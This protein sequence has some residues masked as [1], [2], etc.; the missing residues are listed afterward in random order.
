MPPDAWPNWV[1][2]N[3]DQSR[4]ATRV[5]PAQTRVAAMLLLTLRGT[6]TVYYGDEIGMTDVPIPPHLVQDPAE[7]NQPGIGVGRDPERTPML[8]DASPNGGFTTGTPWLPTGSTEMN[9]AAQA[10]QPDS[11]L[12]LYRQLIALRRNNPA[13]VVGAV[14]K[15]TARGSLLS[16]TRS[17]AGQR[18]QVLLNMGHAPCA[19]PVPEGVGCCSPPGRWRWSRRGHAVPGGG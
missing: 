8:W 2:G 6:P 19:V 10:G 15:V 13:L 7:K 3:H 16:F 12:A 14:G 4:I 9:V 11:M 17:H 1:L 18:L 5:G